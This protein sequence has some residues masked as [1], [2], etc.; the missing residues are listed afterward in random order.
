MQAGIVIERSSAGL[1]PIT[2]WSVPARDRRRLRLALDGD[3][4]GAAI[5]P[6]VDDHAVAGLGDLRGKR[7]QRGPGA[8]PARLQ[9]DEW[10]ALAENL[11]ID[12]N[13]PDIG[14]GHDFP[15]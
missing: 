12:V 8:P 3:P 7:A 11:V 14:D 1:R 2:A 4:R 13:A 10:A 15:P 6:V 9:R 5:A